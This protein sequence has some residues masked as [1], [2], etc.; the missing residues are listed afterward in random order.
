MRPLLLKGHERPITQIKFNKD[1]DLLFSV[2]KDN[3]PTV[4]FAETGE[5][6]G[7]FRGH[8]GAVWSVDVDDDSTRV[9]TGSADASVKMWD[10]KTGK[11]LMH[12][13]QN[14][15]VRWVQF[16]HGCTKFLVV[17][18]SVMGRAPYI[19]I[20][21]N[22]EVVV[23]APGADV[24]LMKIQGTNPEAKIIQAHWDTLNRRIIT[25]GTDRAIRVYDP[26]TGEEVQCVER[27]HEKNITYL[28]FSPDLSHFVTTSSD[29]TAKLWDARTLTHLKTYETNRPVNAAVVSPTMPHVLLGGGQPVETVT[30]SRT[31]ASQFKVRV[32]HKVFE[33][34]IASLAGHFGPVHSLAFSPDGNIF[35]SGGED[36]YIRI[37]HLDD[38]YFQGLSDDVLMERMAP[39][40]E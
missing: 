31:D 29:T 30:Q 15:P 25:G 36:G 17:T 16:N 37:H 23:D 18:D 22:P 3:K 12:Y 34:E 40:V 28:A 21:D 14:A 27:A 35:V 8:N 39:D 19:L 10:V 7:T 6:L 2:S 9:I 4:W 1:G 32:F 13:K 33:D 38:S 5:R 11:E 24:P 20:Y 26:E